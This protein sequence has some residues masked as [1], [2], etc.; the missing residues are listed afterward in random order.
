MDATVLIDAVVRQTTVLIAGQTVLDDVRQGRDVPLRRVHHRLRVVGRVQERT[1]RLGV[2]RQSVVL[3]LRE[4]VFRTSVALRA[5]ID[6][7]HGE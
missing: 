1:A 3:R 6:D 7:D 2:L 4:G 5:R